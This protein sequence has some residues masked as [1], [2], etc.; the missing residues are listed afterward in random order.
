MSGN[1]R[2][3]IGN[4]LQVMGDKVVVQGF[5]VRKKHVKSS[6]TN[7]QGGSLKWKNPIHVSNLKV[8]AEDDQPVKLKVRAD[9]KGKREF[10]YKLDGQEVVYRSVKN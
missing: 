6:Q 9:E 10:Y 2:G 4:S 5:N 8:C 1:D 7:P 3:Q